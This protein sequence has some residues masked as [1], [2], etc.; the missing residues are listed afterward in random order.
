VSAVTHYVADRRTPLRWLAE[1]TGSRGF[2]TMGAP[3]PGH[4][5][6]P[7]LYTGAYSLDQSWH[8]LW[9]LVAALI[10]A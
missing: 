1:H 10:I 4:D 6:N 5:D 7:Q 3:R 8:Y 2:W 9:L